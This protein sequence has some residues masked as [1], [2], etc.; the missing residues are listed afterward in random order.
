M[1]ICF[2]EI[3][4]GR[5]SLKAVFDYDKHHG[6]VY[7]PTLAE[8]TSDGFYKEGYFLTSEPNSYQ[9]GR[10]ITKVLTYQSPGIQG[11]RN[12]EVH[13]GAFP[14]PA[15]QDMHN[16]EQYGPW[17]DWVPASAVQSANL[18]TKSPQQMIED[19]RARMES[20]V[21]R[22][23]SLQVKASGLNSTPTSVNLK[24]R[25]RTQSDRDNFN[26]AESTEIHSPHAP[27][28]SSFT[29]PSSS[30]SLTNPTPNR[31]NHGSTKKAKL[32]SNIATNSKAHNTEEEEML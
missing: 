10:G 6:L 13:D 2:R 15:C 29:S 8:P 27:L 3:C 12:D 24:P 31:A 28:A 23:I 22:A 17:Q 16:Q 11:N 4:D 25:A 18:T 9:R 32:A 5:E 26:D 21:Q 19:H 30:S 14:V 7:W 20:M 1:Y